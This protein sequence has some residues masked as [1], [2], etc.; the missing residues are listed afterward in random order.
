MHVD[1][2]R[3]SS[4]PGR[5]A[6]LSDMGPSSTVAGSWPDGPTLRLKELLKLLQ[7][8]R[9]KAYELMKTDPDFPMGIPLYDCEQSPKFYWTHEAMAWLE[10]RA[11][12]FRNRQKGN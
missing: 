8:S 10:G 2:T 11:T 4:E 5:N 9:S 1:A 12:K 3:P 6:R 7:V